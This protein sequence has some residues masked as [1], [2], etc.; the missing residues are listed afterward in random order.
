MVV[1]RE[2]SAEPIVGLKRQACEFVRESQLE[3][4]QKGGVVENDESGMSA[5]QAGVVPDPICG[6][7]FKPRVGGIAGGNRISGGPGS[8]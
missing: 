4:G 7:P 1:G 6:P 8:N 3:L 2:G 5:H